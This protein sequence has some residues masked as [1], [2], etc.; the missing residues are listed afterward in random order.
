MRDFDRFKVI[1][2]VVEQGLPIWS[3]RWRDP[4]APPCSRSKSATG[5]GRPG[6]ATGAHGY[7]AGAL[8]Q[9]GLQLLR[10]STANL[11]QII[12]CKRILNFHP[13]S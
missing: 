9:R 5:P 7:G 13:L 10:L 12:R 1:Q 3:A 2:A 6:R 4:T 11:P 8:R